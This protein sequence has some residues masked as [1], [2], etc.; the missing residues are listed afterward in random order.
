[1]CG[2]VGGWGGGEG[3]RRMEVVVAV[4]TEAESMRDGEW[5]GE[6]ERDVLDGGTTG[7]DAR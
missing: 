4:E 6:R 7:I 3:V 5:G 2:G 1:M